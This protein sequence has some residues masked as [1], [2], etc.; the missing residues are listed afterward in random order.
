MSRRV[1]NIMAMSLLA[2]LLCSKSFGQN[3]PQNSDIE[4]IGKRNINKGQTNFTSVAKEIEIGRQA[5][6]E[7][8]RNVTLADD[9]AVRDYANRIAQNIAKNSDSQFP[10]TIKVIQSDDVNAFALAGGFIFVNTGAIKAADNEAELGFVIAYLIGHVAARTATEGSAK[11]TIMLVASTPA[12]ILTGGAAGM[13]LREAGQNGLPNEMNRFSQEAVKEADLLGLE[14]LY[15]S[16]Y[17]P[18]AAVSFLGK[19]EI[20]ERSHLKKQSSIFATHPPAADR[21]RFTQRNIARVLP[22][23]PDNVLN[24]SEFDAIKAR[25][26]TFN[27]PAPN[28]PVF[29]PRTR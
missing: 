15:K 28:S 23:R 5:A 3:K 9:P 12:M 29:I 4:N 11:G 21:I 16:G 17:D 20:L 25:V 7:V 10:I 27:S 13:A 1:L 19:L 6:V 24:T 14:Y 2:A 26:M 18:Q 8:E 22:D